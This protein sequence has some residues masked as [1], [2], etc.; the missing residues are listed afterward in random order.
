M[1]I[2]I[3]GGSGHLGTILARAFYPQHEVVVLNR[4]RALKPWRT[5]AWDGVNLGSWAGE[6]DGADVVI[7]LAGRHVN[8]RYTE[9]NKREILQSRVDST[10]VVGEAIA[11]AQNPPHLWIQAS[12]ATVYPHRSDAPSDETT[13]ISE[14]GP[15]AWRFSVE[16]GRQWELALDEAKTPRTRKVKL[17][18]AVVMTPDAGTPFSIFLNLVR[19]GLGGK[20]GDGRQFVSWVHHDD[21]VRAIRFLIDQRF[22]A[23]VVNIAAP[24]PL[25][26]ADFMRAIRKAWGVPFGIPAGRRLLKVVAFLIRSEPELLLKSRRAVSGVLTRN[27]FRFQHP[28]WPE[29][30]IE[31]CDEW[32]ALHGRPCGAPRTQP[33]W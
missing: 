16:V 2:V 13:P 30:A 21:F 11:A 6:I 17:R 4:H 20:A 29:A 27:G 28:T 14:D 19:F 32:R 31:L 9:A 15:A 33:T 25:P 26:N 18:S 24:N 3:P 23:G 7:N 10:R 22:I 8:C 1:K 12:T 5:V